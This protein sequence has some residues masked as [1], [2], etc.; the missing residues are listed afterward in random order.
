MANSDKEIN[1]QCFFKT[2]SLKLLECGLYFFFKSGAA[3]FYQKKYGSYM[4]CIEK[5]Q[6]DLDLR[7]MLKTVY[8]FVICQFSGFTGLI[9]PHATEEER[10]SVDSLRLR[11]Y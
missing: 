9:F 1:V 8:E 4:R 2:G 7:D 10:E 11:G 6:L 5:I 3:A